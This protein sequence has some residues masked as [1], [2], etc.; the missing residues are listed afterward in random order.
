MGA[1]LGLTS[2][3]GAGIITYFWKDSLLVSSVIVI[4]MFLNSLMASLA[5]SFIPILLSRFRSDPAVG[6]GVLATTITDIFG[7]FSFL[8]IAS[9]GLK[10]IGGS[11]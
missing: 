4:A 11:F 5:G 2:G 9:I 8:G 1:A 6:S 7:F 3:L 10:L